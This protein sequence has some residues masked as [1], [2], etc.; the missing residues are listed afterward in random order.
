MS[1]LE[2][3]DAANPNECYRRAESIRPQQAL[4]LVNSSLAMTQSRRLARRLS[5][6]ASS[7]NHF[8]KAAFETILCREPRGAELATSREFLDLQLEQVGKPDQLTP[9]GDDSETEPPS[10]DPVQ[11]ARENLVLV[12]INHNDFVTI[13]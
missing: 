4:A 10:K 11:R 7:D 9:V 12:L 5:D 1:L 3:F 6:T 2:L 8:I 13:R